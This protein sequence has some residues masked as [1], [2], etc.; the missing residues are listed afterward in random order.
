M[1][2]KYFIKFQLVNR[3]INCNLKDFELGINKA[4]ATFN[5]IKSTNPKKIV[6]CIV[7]KSFID[8]ELDSSIEL[9]VPSKALAGFSRKLLEICPEMEQYVIGKRLFQSIEVKNIATEILR[10]PDDIKD[11]DAAKLIIDLFFNN[12]AMNLNNVRARNKI[13]DEIKMILIKF[14]NENIE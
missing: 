6:N 12:S 13:K 3:Q 4:V 8:L 11:L 5:S 7:Y 14:I 10:Y 1:K 2:Y 9:R